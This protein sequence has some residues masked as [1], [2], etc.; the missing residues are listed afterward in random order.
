M[1]VILSLFLSVLSCFC[2]VGGAMI[3]DLL[4]DAEA[5]RQAQASLAEM[6]VG[7][8]DEVT[9]LGGKP[10]QRFSRSR[11]LQAQVDKIARAQFALRNGVIR[12]ENKGRASC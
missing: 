7:L 6:L 3:L 4:R 9:A 11:E 10:Y 2:L 1:L 12:F 5:S 8:A